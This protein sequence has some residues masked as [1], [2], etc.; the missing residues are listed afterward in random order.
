MLTKQELDTLDLLRR[1]RHD[2]AAGRYREIREATGLTQAQVA[3]YIGASPGSVAGYEKGRRHP[4]GD[5]AVKYAL[6]MEEL[7]KRLTD[8]DS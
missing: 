2:M 3:A 5:V 1:S 6:V 7:A 4:R 8:T